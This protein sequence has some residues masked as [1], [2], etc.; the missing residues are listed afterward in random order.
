MTTL[1]GSRRRV[2]AAA[3]SSCCGHLCPAGGASCSRSSACLNLNLKLG[4]CCG[5]GVAACVGWS[6]RGSL[7]RSLLLL[8][9]S[10]GPSLLHGVHPVISTSPWF[11]ALSLLRFPSVLLGPPPRLCPAPLPPSPLLP[12]SLLLWL[13]PFPS[14]VCPL[15]GPLP[16]LPHQ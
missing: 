5:C 4:A 8:S 14:S 12:L 9:W 15:V 3:A 13:A 2:A 6:S 16:I 7:R 1:T 10:P 11:L